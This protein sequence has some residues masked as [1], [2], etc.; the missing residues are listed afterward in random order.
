MGKFVSQNNL[1]YFWQKIKTLLSGK[2]DK[3]EI[4]TNTVKY[5]S[6]SLTDAQKTQART[7]IGAG[8]SNFS[9]K[10]NDLSGKPTIPDVSNFIT[11][12]VNNLTNYTLS[13]GVGTKL[14]L[15]INTSTYVMTISLK[16]SSGTTL[17]TQTVDLPL[18]SMVIGA[19]YDKT[20]K[21][22]TLTL[23]NGTT[24]SFSVADLVSGLV[25]NT[26]KVN[27]K[28]LSS[29]IT[30]TASDVG[31]LPSSTTIPSLDG[32]VKKTG[33]ETISGY[34]QFDDAMFISGKTSKE[35]SSSSS[36][37]LYV[38]GGA[39]NTRI[40]LNSKNYSNTIDFCASGVPYA[41]ISFAQE[42]VSGETYAP[43]LNLY[44]IGGRIKINNKEVAT[45]DM[46]PT[47]NY[48]VT[49]VNSKTGAVSL[50]A[51]DVGALTTSDL[52]SKVYP[53]GSI[54]MS[55]NSTSPASLLGGTWSQLKDRFLLGAGS[56]YSNGATGGSATHTL[57]V[58]EMPSH[59]HDLVDW[60]YWSSSNGGWT[61]FRTGSEST[62]S[63][64]GLETDPAGGGQAHNNMPPYLVVYMWKRTA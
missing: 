33:N 52:L 54:Y 4:P 44:A 40:A 6:Q 48:P 53:V 34:K 39:E 27:G 22:I 11:K 24:T 31:A 10:Y 57:T 1:S 29:D 26:R 64:S 35:L 61:N 23:Q 58:N 63:R 55:V 25:P 47:V 16:N 20:N 7:N 42:Y 21:Q 45:K 17:D 36:K 30:L 12:D 15:S 3:S 32:V 51:S 38:T 28:A 19:S 13:T 14:G 50:T 37:G 5:S 49:S 41:G 8:T 9:G 2:A 46:I 62:V 43:Y 60:V 18:E 59:K 56:S